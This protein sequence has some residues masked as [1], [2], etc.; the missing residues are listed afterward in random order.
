MKKLLTYTLVFLSPMVLGLETEKIPRKEGFDL[1]NN[2]KCDLHLSF[3]SYGS[4]TPHKVIKEI[5]SYLEEQSDLSKVYSWHWGKEGEFDYCIIL[6]NKTKAKDHF[7]K[8]KE[9]IPRYSKNGYTTLND[10]HGNSH[11]TEWPK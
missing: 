4:G 10:L 6:K 11:K 1:R 9:T 3:G 2:K 7:A 5:N 8:L